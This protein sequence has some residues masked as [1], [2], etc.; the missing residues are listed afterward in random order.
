MVFRALEPVSTFLLTALFL[1]GS[2]PVSFNVALALVPIVCGAALTS[3]GSMELTVYGV[4]VV[5]IA[6]LM[7]SARGILVRMAKK[8]RLDTYNIFFY[9]CKPL[10][11]SSLWHCSP[12]VLVARPGA[13]AAAAQFWLVSM[14]W[15]GEWHAG[16]GSEEEHQVGRDFFQLDSWVVVMTGVNVTGFYCY[17]QFSFIVLSQVGVLTHSVCNAMRR[18]A[19]IA[20]SVIYFQNEINLLNLGG[21]LLSCGGALYYGRLKSQATAQ[22]TAKATK[23]SVPSSVAPMQTSERPTL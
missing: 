2:E 21:I 4:A 15:L 14:I 22:A 9:T 8:E 10:S 18:P 5:M 23:S 20:T 7:F 11:L 16:E 1:Q 13:Y 12:A 6:N 3:L 19:I 17:M